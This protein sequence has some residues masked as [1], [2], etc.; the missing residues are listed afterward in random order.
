MLPEDDYQNLANDQQWEVVLPIRS[1][2]KTNY[3]GSGSYQTHST[4]VTLKRRPNFYSFILVFPTVTL[5][6]LS[7]LTYFTPADSGERVSFIVTLLLTQMVNFTALIDLLPAN[8]LNFPIFAYF[9][10]TVVLHM[11]IVCLKA[12]ISEELASLE[13]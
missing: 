10:C 1:Y 4:D 11:A 7:T 12:V 6:L 9:I 8:S 2:V 3:Y 13:F 5:Y